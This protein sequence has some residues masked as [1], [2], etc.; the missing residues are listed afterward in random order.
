MRQI[1]RTITLLVALFSVAALAACSSS[2]NTSTSSSSTGSSSSSDGGS[3]V[4]YGSLSGTLN[5]SGSS[6][7]APFDEAAIAAF[8]EK[9]SGVTVNYGG[10]GSGKGKQDLA[11]QVVDFA[12]SDSLVKD[13]DK[14]NFKGGAFLYFPTV[15]APITMSYNLKG[16]D[17]LQLS[18]DTI[19]KI[20]QSQIKTWDDPAI[21]ADN[22]GVT[23]PSTPITVAHRSD[24]S[25][26]TNNF[27]G[28]LDKAA[29]GVWTLGRGDTVNWPTDT[30]AGNGNRGVAQIVQSA[31]GGIGYVDFA[32]AKA[33]GLSFAAVKNA[34]GDYVAPTLDGVS[35]A[36]DKATINA[37]L[38]YDPLNAAGAD[39]YPIATPTWILVYKNQTD[40]AKGN[41]LKAFLTF[42]LTDGQDLAA[43]ADYA[44]LPDSLRQK[45]L[46]QVDMITVG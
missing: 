41:A 4:D 14:A 23:L 27:T 29:S 33:A 12:G 43:D 8:Q 17:K 19:A 18:A 39:A 31:D 28:F 13:A 36:L 34:A 24:G 7:Q 42:I 1:K 22:P 44:K 3:S 16:V 10:G 38:T 32:D 15:A 35:S 6:F 30:Q 9:A 45:A 26:T 40:T 21:A 11:D 37:D 5:G 25:G 2:G 20:F 46:A